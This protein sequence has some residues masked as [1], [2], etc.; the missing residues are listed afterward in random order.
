MAVP[1]ID[2][3]QFVLILVNTTLH[4]ASLLQAFIYCVH[5][6]HRDRTLVQLMVLSTFFVGLG[7]LVL[8]TRGAYVL[9]VAEVP[10]PDT[11][12]SEYGVADLLTGIAVF[13]TQMY[14]AWRVW[15]LCNK[16]RIFLLSCLTCGA[17]FQLAGRTAGYCILNEQCFSIHSYPPLIRAARIYQAVWVVCAAEDA[18]IAAI[19]LVFIWR[20][21]FQEAPGLPMQERINRL[22]LRLTIVIINTGLW[23][24]ALALAVIITI[25]ATSLESP[26]WTSIGLLTCPFYVN[27]LFANVNSRDYIRRGVRTIQDTIPIEFNTRPDRTSR[28]SSENIGVTA[29]NRCDDFASTMPSLSESLK[30]AHSSPIV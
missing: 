13:I 28:F 12:L 1:P 24:V 8:I 18:L 23:T 17:L 19:L 7:H 6:R 26:L 11:I 22:L 14:F 15:Q 29:T 25:A 21:R 20:N 16:F 10:N 27:T 9:L 3:S 2:P 4:G 30:A 5:H